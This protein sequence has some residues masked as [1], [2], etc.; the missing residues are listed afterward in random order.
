MRTLENKVVIV[1][2]GTRGIGKAIA[3]KF[4]QEGAKVVIN[5]HNNEEAA[6]KAAAEAASMGGEVTLIRGSVGNS[7][8]SKQIIEEARKKYGRIDVLVNNAGI[9]R[10]GFLMMMN[11]KNWDDVITTNLKGTYLCSK[12]VIRTMISQKGGKIINMTSLTGVVGQPGQTNYAASKGGIISFTKALAKEVARFGILVNAIAPGFIAT[13]MIKGVP[14]SVLNEN[15]KAIPLQR[16]GT[17]DEVAGVAL[18]LASD[19]SNYITGQIIN[20]NG[21]QSM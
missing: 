2:G 5:Y 9:T 6:R 11:E 7:K 12:E 21:G 16:T 20:V 14:Q 3:M 13:D 8:D 1:T 4:V 18:F 10:D 17:P 19:M 15:I